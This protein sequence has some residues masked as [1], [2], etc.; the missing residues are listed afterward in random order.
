MQEGQ[1]VTRGSPESQYFFF[2]FAGG[3]HILNTEAQLSS[4]QFE[5]LATSQ[6]QCH[7]CLSGHF[8]SFVD[9]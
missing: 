2:K 8:C 5:G 1:K 9:A 3:I 7:C 4:A 6:Y